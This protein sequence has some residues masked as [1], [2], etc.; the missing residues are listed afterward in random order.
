[1]PKKRPPHGAQAK[2]SDSRP[3]AS[4]PLRSD[5]SDELISAP[6]FYSAHPFRFP[7]ALQ[8]FGVR[9]NPFS[10]HAGAVAGRRGTMTA[11]HTGAAAN[12]V[13]VA[14]AHMVLEL[15]TLRT[16][17][18]VV[19]PSFW[20][21]LAAPAA[22]SG[23]STPHPRL[24]RRLLCAPTTHGAPTPIRSTHTDLPTTAVDSSPLQN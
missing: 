16:E 6:L 15:A 3:F 7:R 14:L 19:A 11:I 9:S 8:C 21:V 4:A 1:M 24:F 20:S 23:L 22:H 17:A 5:V 2:K 13:A 18:L 10:M 12:V